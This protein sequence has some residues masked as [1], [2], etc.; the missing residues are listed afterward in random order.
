MLGSRYSTPPT[1]LHAGPVPTPANPPI[2]RTDLC[3]H[4]IVEGE[5]RVRE[6][7][8][9]QQTV[10]PPAVERAPGAVQVVPRLRLLPRVAVVQ[11]LDR[12]TDRQTDP[13]IC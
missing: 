3:P 12:W 13:A 2:T 6:L 10:Q 9:F 8:V 5:S 11:E 7:E 1:T 4:H